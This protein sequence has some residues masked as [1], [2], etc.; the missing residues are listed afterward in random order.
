[1]N[2]LLVFGC[3]FTYGQG[4]PD[5]NEKP[6]LKPSKLGYVELLGS[7]LDIN[8]KNCSQPG[9]SNLKILYKIL[10]TDIDHDDS[11]LIQW[12]FSSRSY[13]FHEDE[14][15]NGDIGPWGGRDIIEKFYEIH[16]N[17]DLLMKSWL[18]IH[19][20]NLY[21]QTKCTKIYNLIISYDPLHKE[22]QPKWFDVKYFPISFH[23]N[24]LVFC[25]DLLTPW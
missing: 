12:S 5:C 18:A 21:L 17:R 3:S 8:V 9:S 10:N 14:N 7:E 25:A 15:E 24:H 23:P 19:Y 4:L 11:V 20:A 6:W 2:D 13:V 22:I 1:M 16:S